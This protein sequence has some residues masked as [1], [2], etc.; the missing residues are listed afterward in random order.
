MSS[1]TKIL[2]RGITKRLSLDL[3]TEAEEEKQT[4]NAVELSELE[5][6]HNIEYEYK[7]TMD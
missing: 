4:C 7:I 2:R 5:L 1:L 3:R 6:D